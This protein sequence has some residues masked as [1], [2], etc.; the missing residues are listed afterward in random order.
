MK[1]PAGVTE[2][3]WMEVDL[4]KFAQ[5]IQNLRESVGLGIKMMFVIKG[6]GDGYGA[7]MLAKTSIENNVDAFAVA[8]VFEGVDLRKEG[9]NIPILNLG[10][11]TDDEV[12]D[13]IKYDISQTVYRLDIAQQLNDA[14]KA[15]KKKINIH[16][17]VDTGMGRLGVLPEYFEE[18]IDG[19]VKL[20]NLYIE[21]LY[22]HFSSATE[23]N[24]RFTRLQI[25]KFNK[26]NDVLRSKDIAVPLIH[27]ANSAAILNYPEFCFNM[28]RPGIILYG[29]LPKNNNPD[30]KLH[31]EPIGSLKT[32]ISHIKR[33]PAQSPVS[34]DRTYYTEKDSIV[35]TFP[36]GYADAFNRVMSN[37]AEILVKGHRFPVVGKISMDQAM[38][39]LGGFDDVSIGDQVVIFGKDGNEEITITDIAKRINT[40]EHE[41]Q[42]K[43]GYRV[44]RVYMQNGEV[45]AVRRYKLI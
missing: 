16:I 40:S 39:D 21:G 34:Y 38:A 30:N 28:I 45:V 25:E 24:S 26:I 14:A 8:R 7:V 23:T 32:E 31:V 17:S 35:I 41:I 13:I 9:I 6:D 12:S 18:F 19:L 2:S 43:I 1:R 11:F 4:D 3:A 10:Y 33:M 20:K 44:P 5:N 27:A 22:T 42:N 29:S 37:N 15:A 36:V